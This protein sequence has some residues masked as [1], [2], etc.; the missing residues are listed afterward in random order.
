MQTETLTDLLIF[1][2]ADGETIGIGTQ[3]ELD[4]LKAHGILPAEVTGRPRTDEG[5][6]K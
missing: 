2:D 5:S 4:D 1:T 3:A 6:R